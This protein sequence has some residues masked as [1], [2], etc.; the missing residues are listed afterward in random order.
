MM[1]TQQKPTYTFTT[2][3]VQD[4]RGQEPYTIMMGKADNEGKVDAIFIRKL[5]E[6]VSLKLTGAFQS[7]NVEQ[8][9]L[10]AE[11]DVEHNDSLSNF[12]LTQGHWG[13]SLMQ[14]MSPN[15]LAGF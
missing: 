5:H 4:I 11:V 15:F 12:K 3:L 6:N 14:R 9:V 10:V 13:Y 2:Q 7:S 8:G 1:P